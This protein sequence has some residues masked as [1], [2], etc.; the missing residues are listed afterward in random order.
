MQQRSGHPTVEK[1]VRIVCD[2]YRK[3]TSDSAR[4]EAHLFRRSRTDVPVSKTMKRV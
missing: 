2:Y 3:M 1:T 4:A